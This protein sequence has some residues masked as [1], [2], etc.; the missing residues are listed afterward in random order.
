[1]AH[2]HHGR[3]LP[4]ISVARMAMWIVPAHSAPFV[5]RCMLGAAQHLFT[6][7]HGESMLAAPDPLRSG[8]SGI[9]LRPRADFSG[10]GIVL[11]RCIGA[12]RERAMRTFPKNRSCEVYSVSG[13]GAPAQVRDPPS[14]PRAQ[15]RIQHWHDA[16][17]HFYSWLQCFY[18]Y[19]ILCMNIYF[20][21]LIYYSRF[22]IHLSVADKYRNS[23][24]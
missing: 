19:K 2:A 21:T 23:I 22:K 1:M 4:T 18:T 15:T 7:G 10:R 17:E 14:A 5:P 11:Y 12:I 20:K 6:E 9:A 8:F 16:S 13:L 3:S 24:N